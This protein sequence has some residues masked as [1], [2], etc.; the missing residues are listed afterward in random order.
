[1]VS[2]E[3]RHRSLLKNFGDPIPGAYAAVLFIEWKIESQ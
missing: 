3:S 1:M 2:S